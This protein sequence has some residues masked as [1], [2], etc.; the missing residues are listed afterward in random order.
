MKNKLQE[1]ADISLVMK[2]MLSFKN[3]PPWE[4]V[5]L[6]TSSVKTMD[7]VASF[8]YQERLASTSV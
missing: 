7:S 1:D 3:K 5:A 6:S 4:S 2:L 8:G